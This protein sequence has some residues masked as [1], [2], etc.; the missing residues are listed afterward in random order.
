MKK[1][2]IRALALVLSGAM[3]FGGCGIWE[4]YKQLGDM[5]AKLSSLEA[6][7]AGAESASATTADPGVHDSYGQGT[8]EEAESSAE[9]SIEE[10]VV[11]EEQAAAETV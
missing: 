4:K 6:E 9:A 11:T 7:N 1:N 3:L 10:T 2:K 5:E 8:E